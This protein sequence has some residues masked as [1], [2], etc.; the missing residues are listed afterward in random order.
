MK[1]VHEW[2]PVISMNFV[3]EQKTALIMYTTLLSLYI[4]DRIIDHLIFN[5]KLISLQLA[6]ARS[7]SGKMVIKLF[8]RPQ[9]FDLSLL[10]SLR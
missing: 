6:I 5:L 10:V 8:L 1:C 3:Q 4:T 2:Q 9:M 7:R